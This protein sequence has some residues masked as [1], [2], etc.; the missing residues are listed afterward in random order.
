M[1][2]LSY[3]GKILCALAFSNRCQGLVPKEDLYK[4]ANGDLWD[5]CKVCV[6]EEKRVILQSM[7]E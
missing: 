5:M 1:G 2:G 3:D 7:V 4:D 6:E